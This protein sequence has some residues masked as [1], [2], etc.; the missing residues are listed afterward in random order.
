MFGN[1]AIAGLLPLGRA[2]KLRLIEATSIAHSSARSSACNGRASGRASPVV[3]LCPGM[4]ICDEL[5][6]SHPKVL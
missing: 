6:G 2:S 3:D 5:N 1:K 4:A